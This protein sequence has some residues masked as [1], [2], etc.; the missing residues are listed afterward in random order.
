MEQGDQCE[1]MTI[2]ENISQGE[3][4]KWPISILR[5]LKKF[6]A[7][8]TEEAR[9]QK[10]EYRRLRL[11]EKAYGG[12]E[13]DTDQVDLSLPVRK[14]PSVL[15]YSKELFEYLKH[16]RQRQAFSKDEVDDNVIL[17]TVLSRDDQSP[18]EFGV[19]FAGDLLHTRREDE[20]L[21]TVVRR[22]LEDFQDYRPYFSY[23]LSFVHI[24][25]FL[26]SIL[27]YSIA[28]I[29]IDLHMRSDFVF[30]ERLTYEQVAFHE[31]SNFWIGNRPADLIHLG[32]LFAPCMRTDGLLLQSVESARQRENEKSGC[33]VRNDQSGCMQTTREECSPV[34]STFYQWSSKHPGPDDR[35]RGPVCGQDPKH[36]HN[37]V[38]SRP[39]LWSD[40]LTKWP[41]CLDPSDESTEPH[42]TCKVTAKVVFEERKKSRH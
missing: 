37:P 36:C 31:P 13:L 39:N 7:Y 35:I 20:P 4:L 26:V 10:W 14:K 41:I 18:R 15:A 28:N 23:W 40:N 17:D 9:R 38:S 42:M 21:P 1:N 2:E 3:S 27:S 11:A 29:G 19:G 6:R 24:V 16:Y 25:I 8:E 5:A 12:Y 32:A 34:L 22:Q 30:T 33:C